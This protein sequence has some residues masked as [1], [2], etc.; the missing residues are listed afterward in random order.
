M[1]SSFLTIHQISGKIIEIIKESKEY[2]FLV[3][4]YY[5]PWPLLER[6]LEEATQ[7][8]KKIVFIFRKNE[9][10]D[11]IINK[12]NKE[13]QFDIVLL[14]RLHTKLYFNEKQALITSM[15]LYDSSKDY[16]YEMGYSISGYG[17]IKN[18][19][20]VIIE[21]DLLALDT[22]KYY[23]GRYFKEIEKKKSQEKLAKENADQKKQISKKE[24]AFGFCIRC[25]KRIDLNGNYPLCED[26]YYIW[27]Q[28]MNGDYQEKYCH[29]CGKEARVTKNNPFCSKSTRINI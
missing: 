1:V 3:T 13:M 26:C 5:K 8:Q 28:F 20:E 6:A 12:L 25:R 4:P 21:N 19:K 14:E 10:P 29:K 15:N 27:S 23:L 9:V 2:C 7:N 16:N 11:S 24:N 22:H 18:L 17:N